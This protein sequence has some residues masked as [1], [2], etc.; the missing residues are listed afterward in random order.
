MSNHLKSNRHQTQTELLSVLVCFLLQ[1]LQEKSYLKVR[2]KSR[3]WPI[4]DD[5]FYINPVCVK[6]APLTNGDGYT[7]DDDDDDDDYDDDAD[8]DRQ[9]I[10]R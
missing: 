2:R 8:D 10:D 5:I 4:G 6:E 7:R 9:M 1:P 3:N